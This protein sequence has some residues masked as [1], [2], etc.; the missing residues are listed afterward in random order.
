MNQ[1]DSNSA[2]LITFHADGESGVNMVVVAYAD[3][4]VR[5]FPLTKRDFFDAETEVRNGDYT[6]IERES[7]VKKH[8]SQETNVVSYTHTYK[9]SKRRG[10]AKS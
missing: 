3:G 1:F 9:R 7:T 6:L 5:S 2:N 8:P 10:K 4:D